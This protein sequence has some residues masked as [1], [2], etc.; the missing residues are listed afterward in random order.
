[1]IF[2]RIQKNMRKPYDWDAYSETFFPTAVELV[3]RA[4]EA[5]I[6]GH[7]EK[8]SELYLYDTDLRLR[9][10]NYCS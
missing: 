10:Q 5:E 8:A 2:E 9:F 1:M 7:N 4:A 6:E 3:R